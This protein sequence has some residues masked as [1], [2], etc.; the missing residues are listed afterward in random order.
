[1]QIAL[2]SQLSVSSPP[3]LP[4]TPISPSDSVHQNLGHVLLAEV[5]GAVGKNSMKPF[6]RAKGM[7][8]SWVPRARQMG[9]AFS[10]ARFS[11]VASSVGKAAAAS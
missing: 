6:N 2:S 7:A 11:S 3:M 1:M 10:R 8:R 5:P 9:S 4:S